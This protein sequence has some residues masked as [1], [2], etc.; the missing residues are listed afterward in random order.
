MGSLSHGGQADIIE[1][2]NSTSMYLDR[3]LN[4]DNTVELRWLVH[5]S[6]HRKLFVTWVVRA[7][8]G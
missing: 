2:F 7:T 3:L 4:I 8:E 5:L 1:S 6:D